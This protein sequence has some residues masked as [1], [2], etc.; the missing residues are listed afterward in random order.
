MRHIII[1]FVLIAILAVSCKKDP[2]D[3][4]EVPQPQLVIPA[5]VQ[6]LIGK[7]W[8]LQEVN[9]LSGCTNTHYVRGGSS[10]TGA[11]YDLVRFT[12]KADST[13]THTDTQG[14]T[15]PITWKYVASDSQRITINVVAATPVTY[16]WNLVEVLLGNRLIET[17]AINSGSGHTLV[18]ATFVPTTDITANPPALT[19]TQML[20]QQQWRVHEVYSNSS[21]VNTHYLLNGAGNTGANYGALRFKFNADGTGTHTDTEGRNFT[22]SWAFTSADERNIR[23][24]I[25]AAN[26]VVYDWNQ[27]E[28]LPG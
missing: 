3:T 27:V 1:N 13:G 15:Y 6:A 22:I 25:N 26:P 4:P 17:T 8:Q 23:I 16:Q 5:R 12:F 14:N 7:T 24:T 28:L 9:D 19:R 21:C 11:N 20:T 2:V 18:S 10:N